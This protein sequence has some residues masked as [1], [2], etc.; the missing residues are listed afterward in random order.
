MDEGLR[1]LGR[2][3]TPRHAPHQGTGSDSSDH[4]KDGRSDERCSP[5]N[6][7]T[8]SRREQKR[9][10]GGAKA[11]REHAQSEAQRHPMA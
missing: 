6:L 4:A 11:G 8:C 7:G 10:D 9:A 3:V 2:L 1:A 5:R